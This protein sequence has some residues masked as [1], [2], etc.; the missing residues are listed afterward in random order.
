MPALA[1]LASA[2]ASVAEVRGFARAA[3][4]H[5]AVGAS[6]YDAPITSPAQWRQMS[7]LSRRSHEQLIGPGHN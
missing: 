2:A 3:V 6:L 7:D 1:P 5:G 4:E